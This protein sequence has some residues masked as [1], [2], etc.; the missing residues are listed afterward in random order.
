PDPRH[1]LRPVA[2]VE[3]RAPRR[4]GRPVRRRVRRDAAGGRA[5]AV[6]GGR[7]AAGGG[8]RAAR[9]RAPAASAGVIRARHRARPRITIRAMPTDTLDP[10]R[11][12]AELKELRALTG[13]ENG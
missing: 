7:P 3:P 8:G 2:G 11:T 6:F 4:A 9:R 1:R 12:V 13:D 5:G 10:A